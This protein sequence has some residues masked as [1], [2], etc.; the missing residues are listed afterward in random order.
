MNKTAHT[1]ITKESWDELIHTTAA[2]R[3]E[4]VIVLSPECPPPEESKKLHRWL[5]AA[6]DLH[7]EGGVI[8]HSSGISVPAISSWVGFFE[9]VIN[10][11]CRRY[12][13]LAVDRHRRRLLFA[14]PIDIV[15]KIDELPSTGYSAAEVKLLLLM[16]NEVSGQKAAREYYIELPHP[17]KTDILWQRNR[18][19]KKPDRAALIDLLDQRAWLIPVIAAALDVQLR[20]FKFFRDGPLG[21]FNF[22]PSGNDLQADENFCLALRALNFTTAPSF[23]GTAVPEIIVRDKDDL[24]AWCSCPDRLVLLRTAT[25]SLLKPLFDE[26]DERERMRYCGGLLPPRLQTVPVVRSKTILHRQFAADTTLPKGEEALTVE[27]QDVLRSAMGLVLN[28]K[29]AQAVYDQWRRQMASPKAYRKDPFVVWQEVL[30]RVLLRSIFA[31]TPNLLEEALKMLKDTQD[32]RE[33]AEQ[34]RT[35]KIE[36]ALALIAEPSRY[37]REIVDRPKSK[38]EARCLL[39]NEQTAVAFRFSPSKGDDA[40]RNL[41]AFS[42]MSLKRLLRRKECDD[43]LYDAVLTKAE[44]LGLLD[45]RSRTIRLGEDSFAAVTFNVE[46]Y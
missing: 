27:E 19:R 8:W 25:G 35:R 23:M 20:S 29:V 13:L 5:E 10:K 17:A 38:R 42:A 44:Q 24:H 43:D 6:R 39:D 30:E 4:Q 33:Q 14:I 1:G 46:S 18:W 2:V 31:S 9:I 7:L 21:I 34:E 41:L 45:Q 15:D 40:G 36:E 22:T 26:I 3:A 32:M 37:E 16:A 11:R 12:R 28:R